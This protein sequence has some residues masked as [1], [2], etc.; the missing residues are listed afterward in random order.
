[1]AKGKHLRQVAARIDSLE[2]DPLPA[3]SKAIRG[4]AYRKAGWNLYRVDAGEYRIVYDLDAQTGKLTVVT[5]AVIGRRND[6][7][8]YRLMERRLG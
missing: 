6:D 8:V 2:T 7:A 4:D 5:V 3:D 1:M